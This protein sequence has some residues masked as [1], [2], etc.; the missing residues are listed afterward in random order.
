[1]TPTVTVTA[2]PH[3][4]GQSGFATN[5]VFK[6]TRLASW[7]GATQDTEGYTVASET[8]PRCQDCG[9]PVRSLFKK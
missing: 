5:I 8:D 2:C 4:G 3:C 6:A 7:S 9:K 1:M